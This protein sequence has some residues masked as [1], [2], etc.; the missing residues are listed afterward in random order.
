MRHTPRNT[1]TPIKSHKA[2]WIITVAVLTAAALFITSGSINSSKADAIHD[3]T[4]KTSSPPDA[5]STTGP[6]PPA[7]VIADGID[8]AVTTA[9]TTTISGVPAYYWHHGCGPT[10][11]GMVIGYWD[12][13]GYADLLPGDAFTQTVAVNEMIAS[14][15]P[16]SNYTDYCEPRDDWE[17]SPL[18]DKSELPIGDEH[19]DECVAD[20]MKTSQSYHSNFYWWSWFSHMGPA[21]QGY[22]RQALGGDYFAVTE[23]L[24][25]LWDGSLNWDRLRAEIDAGRPMVFL[26]DTDGDGGTDHF[27]TVIGYADTGGTQYYACLNTWD[28]DIH[29]YEFAPIAQGQLWGVFGGTTY[30]ILTLDQ[31]LFLPLIQATGGAVGDV[32][33]PN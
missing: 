17:L 8:M 2:A 12:G 9:A 11:A 25:M 16:A 27:V 13:Q 6:T 10:A 7:G 31:H 22:T 24:Y 4:L 28:D 33:R 15:G 26:V 20:Y 1:K 18:P 19:P 5:Q 14:E 29:W 23:D 21:L 32:D 3:Y 30:R